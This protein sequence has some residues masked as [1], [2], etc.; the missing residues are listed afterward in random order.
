[1]QAYG[2]ILL[3]NRWLSGLEMHEKYEKFI[4]QLVEPLYDH[5]G[6]DVMENEHK[7]SRYSRKLAINLACQFGHEKCLEVTKSKL[8]DAVI[9]PDMQ[10]AIY[11]NG[12][13]MADKETYD[14][15]IELMLNSKYQAYRTLLIRAL[16]S[17]QDE[18]LLKKYL[19]LA[20]DDHDPRIRLQERYRIFSSWPNAGVVGVKVVMEFLKENLAHVNG[21]SPTLPRSILNNAAALIS[22]D[23]LIAQFTELLD[24]LI[25]NGVINDSHK[26]EYL[27][28]V[29]ATKIWQ[30]K[31]VKL[32]EEWLDANGA[33]SV[34]ISTTFVLTFSIIVKLFF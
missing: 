3:I 20:I 2:E 31:N 24:F 9:H 29:N 8:N 25:T 27:S 16:A 5:I 11:S 34:I 14:K 18:A 15:V 19:N 23:A 1:M 32:I 17:T 33:T 30:D 13:R 22:S 4:L 10:E 28:T 26:T 12:L 21:I 7:F 6:L